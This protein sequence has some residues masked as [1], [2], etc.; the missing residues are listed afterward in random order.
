ML[1]NPK[2]K[3]GHFEKADLGPGGRLNCVLT[4]DHSGLHNNLVH[5]QRPPRHPGGVISTCAF[6]NQCQLW[7]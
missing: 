3:E 6:R 2:T 7:S 5:T 1:A 4:T